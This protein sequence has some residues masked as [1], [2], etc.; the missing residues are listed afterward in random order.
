MLTSW[1]LIKGVSLSAF[2][3]V[4]MLTDQAHLRISE[5]SGKQ[6]NYAYRL[7]TLLVSFDP[8]SLISLAIN[9]TAAV[10]LETPATHLGYQWQSAGLFPT[11]QSVIDAVLD[12]QAWAAVVGP[13]LPFRIR[14][15]RSERASFSP[16]PVAATA[17][18]ALETA[19]QVGNSTFNETAVFVVYE[20]ARNE[21]AAAN[22][23]VP[24]ITA[25]LARANSIAAAQ[26]AAE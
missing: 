19:R 24:Q 5:P 10:D 2:V 13:S 12:E 25:L 7:R 26:S 3:C 8:T 20:Q 16:P 15:S 9:A 22:F 4:L 1:S 14:R 17:S 18:S 21:Q 6:R 23:L 11:L